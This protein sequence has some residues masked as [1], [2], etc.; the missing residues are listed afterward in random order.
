M[1]TR[2]DA[3]VAIGPKKGSPLTPAL[4]AAIQSVPETPEY[5]KSLEYSGPGE[6]AI[7]D[8]TIR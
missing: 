5:K 4:Q 3:N 2:K 7:T 1:D 6:S 8:A